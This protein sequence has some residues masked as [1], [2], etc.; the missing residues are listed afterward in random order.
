MQELFESM[1]EEAVGAVMRTE[2]D[3]G[4]VELQR[5]LDMRYFD[6]FHLLEVRVPDGPVTSDSIA[7]AIA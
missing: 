1:A 4:R 7:E 2:A 6:Q 3:R 5:T